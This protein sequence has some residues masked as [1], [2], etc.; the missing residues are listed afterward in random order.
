[1]ESGV[2]CDRF[3][4]IDEGVLVIIFRFFILVSVLLMNRLFWGVYENKSFEEVVVKL[5]LRKFRKLV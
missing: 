2:F 1:M 3:D 5:G 4:S